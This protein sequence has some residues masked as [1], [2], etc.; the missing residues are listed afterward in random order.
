MKIIAFIDNYQQ[1]A[2]EKTEDFD[3]TCHDLR[4][5]STISI[6]DSCVIKSRNPFFIPDF[7]TDFR[8][9]PSVALRICRLGKSIAS[10]FAGRYYTEMTA[11][12]SVRAEHTLAELR[13]KGLPWDDAMIFDRSL[14]LG[15]FIPSAEMTSEPGT[16]FEVSAGDICLSYDTRRLRLDADKAIEEVSRKNT[17]KTGD[18]ILLGL[19]DTGIPLTGPTRLKAESAGHELLNITIR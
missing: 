19:T 12:V 9:Y 10:R 11:A 14:W 1:C 5:L 4:R 2:P 16:A 13:M 18:I 7:D 6:P 8:A 17:V 15:E 3:P